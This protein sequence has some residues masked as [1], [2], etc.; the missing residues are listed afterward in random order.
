MVLLLTIQ[1]K[2]MSKSIGNVVDPKDI[3]QNSGADILRFW[4]ASQFFRGEM[5]FPKDF[6]DRSMTVLE[7]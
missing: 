7:E 5:V 2:K 3:I 6:F 4:I 1:E